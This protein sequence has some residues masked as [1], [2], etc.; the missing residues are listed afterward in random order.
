M[1][2]K[3]LKRTNLIEA[4][5]ATNV[6]CETELACEVKDILSMSAQVT[7]ISTDLQDNKVNYK[8]RV[9]FN[10]IYLL[11]G[12]TR[13]K[14]LGVEFI[15][16][17]DV[18]LQSGAKVKVE[19]NSEAIS[20][21]KINKLTLQT[22]ITAKISAET[23]QTT[24]VLG[25]GEEYCL[26]TKDFEKSEICADLTQN[27][28]IEDQVEISAPLR[29]VLS[30]NARL[31]VT[32]CQCGI[33]AVIVDGEI[34]LSL[35]LLPFDEKSDI[36]K[37]TRI[38]PFRLELEGAEI[39]V[40]DLSSADG[41]VNQTNL[42]VY[43]DEVKGKTSVSSEVAI[44]LFAKAY[45][46][47]N[48][49]Y[50]DDMFCVDRDLSLAREKISLKNFLKQKCRNERVSGKAFCTPPENSR[51]VCVL[52]ERV[53]GVTY[54]SDEDVTVE[55]VLS[56]HVLFENLQT[57]LISSR[58]AEIPFSVSFGE[59]DCVDALKCVCR[60]V[61]A[62]LRSDEVEMD[63]EISVY[64]QTCQS[65]ELTAITQVEEGEI[66][67][68][69]S[70]AFMVYSPTKSDTLWDI[71]KALKTPSDIILAQ[72]EGLTFPLSGEEKIIVYNKR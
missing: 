53:Y 34:I 48:F 55:G 9:I 51:L 32:G 19:L 65:A 4:S 42:K 71:S 11:E 21:N 24:N 45:K 10:V 61:Q 69:K 66:L 63:G 72:N 26:N 30:S 59:N 40:T 31:S 50:V 13:R 3:Q 52:E 39:Q 27:F 67:Q 7:L 16:N 33:G 60:G 68:G 20:A 41:L 62:R 1:N 22:V 70:Y 29:N 5:K 23:A 38:I 35:A 47:I 64:Y 8:G 36:I 49:G 28:T 46:K 58:L 37:E 25:D 15:E 12:E 18:A 57:G 2:Y 43:V 44:T 54:K 14:E 56:A 6:E 17:C